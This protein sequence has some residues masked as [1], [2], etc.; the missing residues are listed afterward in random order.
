M[1][2]YGFFL[3][4]TY[5][6]VLSVFEGRGRKEGCP[7]HLDHGIRVFVH[8]YI[9]RAG[10]E[11]RRRVLERCSLGGRREGEGAPTK[12]KGFEYLFTNL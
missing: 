1:H 9:M 6:L 7:S 10:G 4:T 12:N 2:L 11:R 8:I 5:L 3:L